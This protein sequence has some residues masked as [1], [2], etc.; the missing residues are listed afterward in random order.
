MQKIAIKKTRLKM[1]DAQYKRYGIENKDEA[2]KRKQ[3]YI[4]GLKSWASRAKRK[5][6]YCEDCGT[7]EELH[8][9]HVKPKSIYPDL[10]LDDNNVK[11]LCKTCHMQFHKTNSLY[12]DQ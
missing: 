8:A 12:D 4:S 6:P 5:T 7:K 11:I 1:S 2:N 9:H 10:A 3:L